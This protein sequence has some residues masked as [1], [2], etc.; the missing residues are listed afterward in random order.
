[1]NKYG[2]TGCSD[3]P[4]Y[5]YDQNMR[6]KSVGSLID[7]LGLKFGSVLDYGCCAGEFSIMLSELYSNVLG[8]DISATAVDEAERFNKKPNIEFQLLDETIFEHDYDLILSITVLQ[9]I[10]DD[11]KLID[12]VKKFKGSMAPHG[13]LILLESFSNCGVESNYLKLREIGS[14]IKI[15]ED[16]GIRLQSSYDFYHPGNLPTKL[17]KRY[18]SNLIIRILNRLSLSGFPGARFILKKI[19]LNVSN[20]DSGIVSVQSITKFLVFETEEI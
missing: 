5:Y 6:L 18:R 12:L 13:Q 4:T 14:L 19:A 9:H 16:F 11:V 10:L 17:F 20:S 8:T 1:V 15:F 2:H 3:F 7:K